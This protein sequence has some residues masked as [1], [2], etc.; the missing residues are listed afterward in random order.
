MNA[1]RNSTILHTALIA[2]LAGGALMGGYET[3]SSDEPDDSEASGGVATTVTSAA[4][5]KAHSFTTAEPGQCLTWDVAEDGT[6]SNFTTVDCAEEHRFEISSR[7]DL[8]TYPS[9]EFGSDAA[10]PDITRQAQLREELCKQQTITYLGGKYDPTGVY[11]IASI[12]P[13]ADAWTA[14]DRTMLCG[15]QRT[16]DAGNIT[17]SAGKAA[18]QDQSRVAERGECVAIDSANGSH[19]VD[20]GQPHSYEVTAR[21]NLTEVFDHPPTTEE[22]DAHLK[23]VCTQAALDY[24]G[25]DDPLYNSW[26]AVYWTTIPTASWNAGSQSAN[27]ALFRPAEGGGFST[28]QGSAPTGFT[29]DGNPPAPRPE[30]R[31]LRDAQ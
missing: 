13:P 23:D 22:Q 7:E 8:A 18:N 10:A 5:P 30:R 20:C 11:S 17:T 15:V 31:P 21:V 19:K 28:L 4:K 3:M 1:L 24:M 2:A 6:T 27:C 14:G 16:D 9:S 26:L 25:G 12:L 29:I